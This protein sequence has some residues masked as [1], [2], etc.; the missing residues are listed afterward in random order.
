MATEESANPKPVLTEGAISIHN[1][2]EKI[3]E[4]VVHFH[5]MKMKDCFFLWVGATPNLSN[6]AVA[7]CSKFDSVPLSTLV[8]GDTSDTTSNSL[9]QRL[10]CVHM[11]IISA[12]TKTHVQVNIKGLAYCLHNKR[13]SHVVTLTTVLSHQS[14][15]MPTQCQQGTFMK[16]GHFPPPGYRLSQPVLLPLNGQI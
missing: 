2:S 14:N 10:G 3:L 8:L 15:A 11:S 5:V 7:M 16:R 12:S 9:A 1:F 6:L 13:K 4:Q